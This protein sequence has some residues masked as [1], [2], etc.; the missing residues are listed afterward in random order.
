M[1][2]DEEL[3]A[4]I[5]SDHSDTLLSI[6][7]ESGRDALKTWLEYSESERFY[8]FHISNI[9]DG[10]Y[11]IKLGHEKLETGDLIDILWNDKTISRQHSLIIKEYPTEIES[12]NREIT[13]K[14]RYPCIK[15]K[16]N[17]TEIEIIVT[18]CFARKS[19]K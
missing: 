1:T 19:I 2:D 7:L 8:K 3:L 5:R 11:Q 16:Y 17:N 9:N 14:F 4:K 6:L 15:I 12:Y 13:V 18:N 10:D